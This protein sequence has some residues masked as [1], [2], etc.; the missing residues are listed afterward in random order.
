MS[1]KIMACV[2]IENGRQ[3]WLM[4]EVWA[5]QRK[6]SFC[7]NALQSLKKE[8]RTPSKRKDIERHEKEKFFNN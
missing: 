6:P 8:K 4:V 2:V 3:V 5:G 7:I 1:L